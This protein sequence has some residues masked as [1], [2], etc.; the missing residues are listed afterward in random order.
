MLLHSDNICKSTVHVLCTL[1]TVLVHIKYPSVADNLSPFSSDSLDLL[2]ALSVEAIQSHAMSRATSKQT[3]WQSACTARGSPLVEHTVAID[4]LA[5][6][7]SLCLAACFVH[8]SAAHAHTNARLELQPLLVHKLLQ[9]C[10]HLAGSTAEC[11][12]TSR[13]S[14]SCVFLRRPKTCSWN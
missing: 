5:E 6:L 7:C 2:T 12:L 4:L 9:L 3:V 8:C 14:F 11:G 1:H 10:H 13:S